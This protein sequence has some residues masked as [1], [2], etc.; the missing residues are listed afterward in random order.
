M[1]NLFGLFVLLSFLLIAGCATKEKPMPTPAPAPEPAPVPQP[2]PQPAPQ[3]LPEPKE[4]GNLLI[5]VTDNPL[6]IDKANCDFELKKFEIELEGLELKE[7]N[8]SWL[9]I[10]FLGLNDTNMANVTIDLV[11]LIGIDNLVAQQVIEVGQFNEVRFKVQRAVMTQVIKIPANLTNLTA[12]GNLTANLTINETE[13]L[14]EDL[15]IAEKRK[16]KEFKELEKLLKE[17]E[18]EEE[19]REELR[20][21]LEEEGLEVEQEV[22][23][24]SNEIKLKHELEIEDDDNKL[25]EID[26]DLRGSFRCADG[27]IIFL[28]VIDLESLEDLEFDIKSK[29]KFEERDGERRIRIKRELKIDDGEIELK[30]R[31]RMREFGLTELTNRIDVKERTRLRKQRGLESEKEID[32]EV[33][34]GEAKIELEIAGKKQKFKLDTDNRR[35]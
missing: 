32:I 31:H 27:K 24:P 17:E 4:T 30:T 28:P 15:K 16:K 8:G 11:E 3:P 7:L 35:S 14:E 2:A 33:D 5:A 34:E 1:K 25:L 29:Q 26:F 9:E 22:K 13:E 12:F 6:K 18:E 19:E 21:K 23:I 20:K 10:P